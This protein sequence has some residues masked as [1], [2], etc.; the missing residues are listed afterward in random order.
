MSEYADDGFLC[1][2]LDDLFYIRNVIYRNGSY[3]L[4]LEEAVLQTIEKTHVVIPRTRFRS[5]YVDDL[6]SYIDVYVSNE[7]DLKLIDSRTWD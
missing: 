3:S 2:R 5:V 6:E 7:Y 1:S 4:S